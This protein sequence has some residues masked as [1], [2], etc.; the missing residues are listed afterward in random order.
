MTNPTVRGR[1][2]LLPVFP[3]SI[4]KRCS[5]LRCRSIATDYLQVCFMWKMHCKLAGAI[6]SRTCSTGYVAQTR[7]QESHGIARRYCDMT[8]RTDLWGRSLACEELLPVAIE[9]RLVLRELSYIRKSRLAFTNFFPVSTGKLVARITSQLLP[10]DVSGMRKL[11]V[12]NARLCASLGCARDRIQT[13]AN[14][15]KCR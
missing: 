4:N 13:K 5:P 15:Q 12:I 10:G 2:L 8:I 14:N 11:R 7:K 6:A 3:R 9:T 1:F